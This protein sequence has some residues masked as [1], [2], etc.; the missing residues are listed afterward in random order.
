MCFSRKLAFA[1]VAGCILSFVSAVNAGEIYNNLP[2]VTSIGSFDPVFDDGPSYNSFSTGS[3]AELLT[4]IKM[5]LTG[6]GGTPSQFTVSLLADSSNAPGSL[7]STLGTFNDSDKLSLTA[8]VVDVSGGSYAL[9]AN[10]R[11]WVELS[12]TAPSP[13][14]TVAWNYAS[15]AAGV[16]VSSEYW[17]YTPGGVLTVS[18]NSDVS[19]P[20]QMSV[21]TSS[22]VP[23]PGTFC[24]V[25]TALGVGVFAIARRR[26]IRS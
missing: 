11:Y 26:M 12:S 1:T 10:T 15:S 23:E 5:L 25:L 14:S 22:A 20:Y 17:A 7:L 16:G 18:A 9:A 8:S 2:P 19:T 24:Q 3:N 6:T 21:T 13:P 4:D